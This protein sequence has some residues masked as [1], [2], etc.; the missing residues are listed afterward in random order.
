VTKREVV[1][2]MCYNMTMG[3]RGAKHNSS[4]RFTGRHHSEKTK[5]RL[6]KI[7]SKN[8]T[9]LKRIP[10]SEEWKKNMSLSLKGI[11]RS[12]KTRNEMSKPKSESHRKKIGLANLGKKLS[13]ETKQKLR[14]AAL[15]QHRKNSHET[16]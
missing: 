2:P 3:G 5:K 16:L 15:N 6:S 10:F 13:E 4:F 9:G 7:I 1:D 12:Q 11:K 14:I 8:K